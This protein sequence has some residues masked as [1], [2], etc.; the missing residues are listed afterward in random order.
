MDAKAPISV[1]Q[2]NT[3]VENNLN[4]GNSKINWNNIINNLRSSGKVRL[5]TSLANTK[6]NQVGDLI[7]EIEFPNGL[8]PFVQG[9]LEDNS[10]KKDLEDILFKE[11]GKQWHIKYKD[12][13]AEKKS[14]VPK[15]DGNSINN[16]GLDINVIE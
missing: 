10:N 7:L 13:K 3:Q 14:A 11:T 6:L 1:G 2:K 5:Y 8:T 4:S 12:G 16:L 15:D 9:I